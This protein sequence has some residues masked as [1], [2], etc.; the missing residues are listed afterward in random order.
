MAALTRQSGRNFQMRL[1]QF[2]QVS[3][4]Q[5]HRTNDRTNISSSIA[6]LK[7]HHS[8]DSKGGKAHSNRIYFIYFLSKVVQTLSRNRFRLCIAEGESMLPTI[9]PNDVYLVDYFPPQ[10]REREGGILGKRGDFE[11]PNSVKGLP[12][13]GIWIYFWNGASTPV[14][15][16]DIVTI[17]DTRKKNLGKRVVALPGDLV[18]N[19][20][21]KER[22]QQDGFHPPSLF[23][24]VPDGHVWVEGDNTSV[25]RDS[26]HFGPVPE[27][28]VTRRHICRIWP[29]RVSAM[30]QH[31][32]TPR[33]LD[34]KQPTAT[35]VFPSGAGAEKVL[36]AMRK[37][38]TDKKS[39]N[40]ALEQILT[41]GRSA[42]QAPGR[43]RRK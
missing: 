21:E 38:Y 26:R 10:W 13:P 16:G 17:K 5:R 31:D 30:F 8:T 1:P 41:K 43:K 15:V 22:Q 40:P 27:A 25:S 18:I 36:T 12:L 6:D 4:R 11:L 2:Q 28:M 37:K 32:P 7:R 35:V 23:Q 14:S 33:E 42:N 19:R 39:M 20:M 9:K 29:P 34:W 24:I 3:S